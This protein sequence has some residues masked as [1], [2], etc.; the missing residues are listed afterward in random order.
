M[1]SYV[2][3]AGT[4]LAVCI[5]AYFFVISVCKPKEKFSNL[6]TIQYF[7]APWC[8]HCQSFTPTWEK[9]AE[10]MTGKAVFQKIDASSSD[11]QGSA[12]SGKELAKKE[13]V[14]GF[15]HIQKVADGKT[16]VFSGSP[17]TY[18]NVKKFIEGSQ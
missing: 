13:G 4:A 7:F 15:P 5:I 12:P 8:G 6:P 1:V 9:L 16:I 14:K 3:V 11:S 17:R 18:E 10:E 2:I